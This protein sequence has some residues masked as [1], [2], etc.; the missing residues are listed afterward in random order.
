MRDKNNSPNRLETSH[1]QPR[2]CVGCWTQHRWYILL[3]L[4][5][6][7]KTQTASHTSRWGLSVQV[8]VGP[9]LKKRPLNSQSNSKEIKAHVL[10]C[11]QPTSSNGVYCPL[12]QVSIASIPLGSQSTAVRVIFNTTQH[13]QQHILE[14][15]NKL[16]VQLAENY[17]EGPSSLLSTA[18]ETLCPNQPK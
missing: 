9:F 2:V 17:W 4:T 15:H 12:S 8:W 14:S 11:C 1:L 5:Q 16:T 3:G 13:K 18:R 7:N 10:T 6:K